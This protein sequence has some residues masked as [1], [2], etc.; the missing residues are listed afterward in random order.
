MEF[1]LGTVEEGMSC[2]LQRGERWSYSRMSL[3]IQCQGKDQ[4]IVSNEDNYWQVGKMKKVVAAVCLDLFNFNIF[5]KMYSLRWLTQTHTNPWLCCSQCWMVLK[6]M[7]HP[8]K[9]KLNYRSF[10]FSGVYLCGFLL[11]PCVLIV[12]H[13]SKGLASRIFLTPPV[14][15]H[16]SSFVSWDAGLEMCHLIKI[17]CFSGFCDI[18]VIFNGLIIV[19]WFFSL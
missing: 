1:R 16:S 3:Q 2:V 11:L 8:A 19:I 4:V 10:M 14:L 6:C 5:C 15:T 7:G 18:V 9:G 13:R 17:R 12:S